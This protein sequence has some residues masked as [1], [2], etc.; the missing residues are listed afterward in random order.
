MPEIK[1]KNNLLVNH[2]TCGKANSAAKHIVPRLASVFKDQF[3]GPQ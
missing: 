2:R 1:Q 3:Q